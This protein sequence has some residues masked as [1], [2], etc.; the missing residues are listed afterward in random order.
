MP[1]EL[2]KQA[3]R[4]QDSVSLRL[5]APVCPVSF[6]DIYIYKFYQS[7]WC[8]FLA[9]RPIGVQPQKA[10]SPDNIAARQECYVIN[11]YTAHQFETIQKTETA[12]TSGEAIL[13][14]WYV[15]LAWWLVVQG[16]VMQLNSD[17][18]SQNF[19]HP[20]RFQ[21][22]SS[23]TWQRSPVPNQRDS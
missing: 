6:M 23:M 4:K 7:P 21:L 10:H 3:S 22:F 1:A 12:I 20:S 13:L 15:D 19:E 11:L 5:F 16:R 2:W 17:S 8:G 14:K 9:T 18:K